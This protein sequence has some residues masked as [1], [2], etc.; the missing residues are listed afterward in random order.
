MSQV[1]ELCQLSSCC[2]RQLKVLAQ[3]KPC[4]GLLEQPLPLLTV[5]RLGTQ[6][7]DLCCKKGHP[8]TSHKVK[9]VCELVAALAT[10]SDHALQT[11]I[12]PLCFEPAAC[13]SAPV[14]MAAKPQCVVVLGHHRQIVGALFITLI[15][16]RNIGS[17]LDFFACI[18]ALAGGGQCNTEHRAH[19]E[20]GLPWIR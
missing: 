10:D 18:L 5:Y 17:M 9:S 8:A 12:C 14:F 1:G 16:R 13:C 2:I 19:C 4:Q 15:Q 11:H 6:Q 20:L 3:R 7:W